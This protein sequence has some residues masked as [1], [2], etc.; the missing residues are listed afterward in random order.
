MQLYIEKRIKQNPYNS[1]ILPNSTPVICFGD[2]FNSK[3]ATLGLNPS[4]KEFVDNSNIFLAGRFLRFQ[5]CFSLSQTDLTKVDNN[6]TDLVLNNCIDYFKINPYR[7]WFD[8]LENY[9]LKKINI[10]YYTKTCCHLD[11]VQW[12]TSNK[13][14]DVSKSNQNSLLNNDYPF[15]IQQLN[16]QDIETLLIN[17]K[18][19]FDIINSKEKIYIL[20]DETI[21]VKSETCRIIKF[22]IKIGTKIINCFAWSKNLQSA[23]GLTNN[24]RN[25]IGDWILNNK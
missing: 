19:V 22:Y 9:I 1:E 13:W 2:L 7:D 15:L 20:K 10:S 24:M 14:R 12:A 6:Q 23:I 11:V 18:G 16:N 8:V 17:G 4:N 3:I 21:Y 5:N 25:S